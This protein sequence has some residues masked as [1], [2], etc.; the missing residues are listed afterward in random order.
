MEESM[1][2]C[3]LSGGVFLGYVDKSAFRAITFVLYKKK[4][5]KGSSPLAF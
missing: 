4:K 5:A 2:E 1:V 3:K